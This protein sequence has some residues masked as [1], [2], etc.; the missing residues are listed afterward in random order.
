[1]SNPSSG[2]SHPPEQMEP[3]EEEK[4]PTFKEKFVFIMKNLTIEPMIVLY[5]LSQGLMALPS[6]NFKT[7]KA[8]RVNFNY[9]EEICDVMV[10]R[11]ENSTIDITE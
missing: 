6:L 4:E 3:A 9:S 5:C 7:L 11:P 8:C 1:M 10:K 2:Q